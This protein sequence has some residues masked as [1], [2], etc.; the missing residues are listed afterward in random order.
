[1]GSGA[2]GI[3]G[4]RSR[5]PITLFCGGILQKYPNRD[6]PLVLT[7]CSIELAYEAADASLRSP[8]SASSPLNKE[9]SPHRSECTRL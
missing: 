7:R 3:F 1:M 8:D 4:G 2:F 5:L 9:T 6:L